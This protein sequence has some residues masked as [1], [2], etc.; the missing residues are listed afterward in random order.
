MYLKQLRYNIL[1]IS[2]SILISSY[3][4]N[5]NKEKEQKEQ[6]ERFVLVIDAGHGGNDYGAIGPNSREKDITLAVSLLV[7]QY[8]AKKHPDVEI[9]YIRDKDYFVCLPKRS[10]IANRVKSDLFIS[11]HANAAFNI[12]ARGSEIYVFGKTKNQDNQE[13][14]FRENSVVSLENDYKVINEEFDPKKIEYSIINE[15]IKNQFIYQ[16]FDFAS[17]LQVELKSCV[18]WEDR[19]IK[20]ANYSVLRNSIGV[21]VLIELDFI[22]NPESEMY[23]LSEDGQKRYAMAICNAFTKYK[24]IY[25]RNKNMRIKEKYSN[26]KI[27]SKNEKIDS[28]ILEKK[29]I[30]NDKKVVYKVQIFTS[31]NKLQQDDPQFKGYEIDCYEEDNLYKYTYGSSSNIDEIL[32]LQKKLLSVFEGAFIICFEKGVKVSI[33][34]QL[35]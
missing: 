24:M 12:N 29:R 31:S 10:E 15:F 19:G 8:I 1:L 27:D 17:I 5:K 34:K 9:I 25:D 7:G 30:E 23:L 33:S 18:K 16:S 3:T 20:Q 35:K 4:T 21:R 11:I 14:A 13:V 22:T 32:K 2:V 28:K 26:E 6:K